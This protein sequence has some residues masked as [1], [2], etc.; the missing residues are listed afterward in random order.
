[1]SHSRNQLPVPFG[2]MPRTTLAPVAFAHRTAPV[3]FMGRVVQNR[4]DGLRF[5]GRMTRQLR[6]PVEAALAMNE[7]RGRRVGHHVDMHC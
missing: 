3:E 1:M 7:P 2:A 4:D 6:F 5:E